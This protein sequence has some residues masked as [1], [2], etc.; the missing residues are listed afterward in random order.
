MD[1]R[2]LTRGL[3]PALALLATAATAPHR[4]EAADTLIGYVNL[5]RAILE[6]E[7][8]KSAKNSLKATFDVKQ[9]KLNDKEAELMKVKETIEREAAIKDD[10]ETRKKVADFQARLV[11][12]QQVFMKEQ[13]ELQEAE[14]KELAGITTKMRKIIEGIGQGGGYTMILEIQ[15][16][17]LLF[18]KAH[19]D[20]TNEV[21]RKYNAKY[22]KK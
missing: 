3:L 10:P 4:A 9:K 18:A 13:K 6:V 7:E 21:I 16:S 14:Q 22:P 1:I 11:D 20:L 12:L 8:G 17:R 15:D 19:L 5:Q 2:S